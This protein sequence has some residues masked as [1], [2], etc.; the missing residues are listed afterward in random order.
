[1]E[2]ELT[3]LERMRLKRELNNQYTIAASGIN[4]LLPEVVKDPKKNWK[5][6]LAQKLRR[7]LRSKQASNNINRHRMLT[8]EIN[9]LLRYA[10]KKGLIEVEQPEVRLHR[11]NE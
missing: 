9:K 8:K 1:M 11:I 6:K 3:P 4:E 7:L 2:N 10:G 5:Q